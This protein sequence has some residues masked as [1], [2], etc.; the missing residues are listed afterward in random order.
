METLVEL[1][2]QELN[3]FASQLDLVARKG[4]AGPELMDHIARGL[5]REHRMRAMR[6]AEKLESE[7]VIPVSLFFFLPFVA[8]VMIPLLIPLLGAF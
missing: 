2:L 7:L 6:S 5:A 8:A 4:A 1:R 3:A